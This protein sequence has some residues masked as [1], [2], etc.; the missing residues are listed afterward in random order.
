MSVVGILGGGQLAR[1]LALAGHPLGVRCLVLDPSPEA[2]AGAV[3]ELLP[4]SFDDPDA[5]D[6]L[7][8]EAEVVTYEFEN[9]PTAA[10]RELERRGVLVLPPLQALETASDR[11]REKELVAALGGAVPRFVAV[12]EPKALM[13]AIEEVGF[14]AVLKTRRLGYDGKGQVRVDTGEDALRGWVQL[15]SVPCLY[16][17]WVPFRR[18]LAQLAVRGRNG[19][20]AFYPLV[21]TRQ[22][23]GMLYA[24]LAPAPAISSE[25]AQAARELARKVAESLNFVGVLALELFETEDGLVFNE[26][27]PRVHNSGHWTIEGAATSQFEN[28]LRAVLG[29]PLGETALR[30]PCALRNLIGQVP[31]REPVL[32]LSNVHLHLYGKAPRPGRKVGHVTL[33]AGSEAALEGRL[34]ELEGL[35]SASA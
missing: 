2:C 34:A 13:Q 32:A 31:A 8:Q 33:L 7:A 6:R 14:P 29:W 30:T 26:L 1:M 9:V 22:R 10:A 28:H 15:G 25:V 24:L 16:E 18:E 19:D 35:L 11:L 20:V 12:S 5:L 23:N 3:A 21:E 4:C 17:A 27:A